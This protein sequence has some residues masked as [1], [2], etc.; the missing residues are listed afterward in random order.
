[1][2]ATACPT[3]CAALR[4]GQHARAGGVACQPG[5]QAG[6]DRS[7]QS[8][9]TRAATEPGVGARPGQPMR[10]L[11]R[12]PKRLRRRGPRPA[13]QPA[14]VAASVPPADDL[15]PLTS[16][17]LSQLRDDGLGRPGRPAGPGCLTT[18]PRSGPPSKRTRFGARARKSVSRS[19]YLPRRRRGGRGVLPGDRPPPESRIDDR[20]RAL[21]RPLLSR[22]M[23]NIRSAHMTKFVEVQRAEWSS[24][25]S[26]QLRFPDARCA[27]GNCAIGSESAT[28]PARRWSV[29]VLGLQVPPPARYRRV[30]RPSRGRAG[31]EPV[32]SS[33]MGGCGRWSQI[34]ALRCGRRARTG[35]AQRPG[36]RAGS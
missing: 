29:S 32:G 5:T 24:A 13:R 12:R 9:R 11:G 14:A 35:P 4:A 28:I 20:T 8:V 27:Y 34:A 15:K 26:P 31:R 33:K 2:R 36:R 17:Q 22:P 30:A 3:R 1:M 19:T 10:P 6:Q 25:F 18:R 23:P 16:Q 21:A 7:S